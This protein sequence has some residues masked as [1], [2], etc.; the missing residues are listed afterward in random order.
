MGPHSGKF[1][2]KNDGV[3]R[4]KRSLRTSVFLWHTLLTCAWVY[5]MFLRKVSLPGWET[6]AMVTYQVCHV[7]QMSIDKLFFFNLDSTVLKTVAVVLRKVRC[8]LQ[9]LSIVCRERRTVF[10]FVWLESV[11]FSSALV[12]K[13]NAFEVFCFLR[14]VSVL[15]AWL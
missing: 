9:G 2:L 14:C 8:S 15:M 12:V 6:F 3:E 5:V 1:Y 7:W 10:V 4:S 11:Q 13:D